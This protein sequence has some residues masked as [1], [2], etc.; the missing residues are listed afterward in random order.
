[1]AQDKSNSSS[2]RCGQIGDGEDD[3]LTLMDALDEVDRLQADANAVLGGSDEYNCTYPKGY[4]KRQAIYACATCTPE[5]NAGICLACSYACHDGHDLHELY[6]KRHFKCD[7][8]NEKFKE[9]SCQIYKEKKDLN[10]R[11][12]YNQNFCGLYCTCS[13]PYPDEEDSVE[14]EMIQCIVCEDWYHGRHLRTEVPDSSDYHEMICAGCMSKYSFLW[15]YHV[16]CALT[17]LVPEDSPDGKTNIK[18]DEASFN[19]H[20]SNTSGNH[21]I[22]EVSNN[23]SLE[24]SSDNQGMKACPTSGS[25]CKEDN[26]SESSTSDILKVEKRKGVSAGRGNDEGPPV[27]KLK[28]DEEFQLKDI[29]MKKYE[30]E[31]GDE[32]KTKG[33]ECLLKSLQNRTVDQP[34]CATFWSEGWRS[35]LCRCTECMEMYE[36]RNIEYLI[37]DEDTMQA[38]E[39]KACETEK[40]AV[41]DDEANAA[42]FASMGRVQQIEVAQG[43]MDFKS[44]LNEF[45][46]GF[47][48]EGKVV[49]E[50]DVREFFERMH[51]RRRERMQLPQHNCR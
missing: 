45:L 31:E 26:S 25:C 50:S 12:R 2:R 48:R 17:S 6:T 39:E 5:G 18:I 41:A 24:H 16:H 21:D 29:S 7:C 11:N 51:Q 43:L 33:S 32:L 8:G 40:N 42:A 49:K 27:K 34:D 9:N 4:L 20:S 46:Q 37:D 22:N 47:A 13:R 3:H 19:S 28:A 15:A 35:K 44:E 30:D 23:S 14:D 36:D 1:M 38:Y 10:S